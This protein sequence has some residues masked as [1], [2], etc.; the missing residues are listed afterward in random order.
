MN[1]SSLLLLPAAALYGG[2][3][4]ARNVY[5]DRIP[6]AAHTAALPVISVGNITAGGTGKT[7]LVIEIVRR[8]AAFGR[9]PAIL[10]RGYGGRPGQPADEVLELRAALSD[11]PVVVNPDRVAGAGEAERQ[12][13]DCVVLDDGFQHRRLRR[14]LDIV[15]VDALAPW[16]GGHLL[17]AGRLREPLAGLRRA[18]LFVITRVNL[19]PPGAAERA[20]A[21][22]GRWAGGRPVLA[23]SVRPEAVVGRGSQRE[24]PGVLAGRRVL[25]VAGLGNPR[26][27]ERTVAALAGEVRL[28]SFADHQRYAAGHVSRICAEV[29]RWG[30]EM[31]VTTRKD[32]GKLA[33]LW[34]DDG[35][36]LVRLDV[37]L[38]IEDRA[39]ELDAHLRRALETH[40]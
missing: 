17:P 3:V 4:R 38:T 27:F 1:L 29:E 9:R 7:P 13:A 18:G 22:L 10:T 31:V 28:L 12:G 37:R 24:V 16:G 25:A 11:T 26:G 8:L 6:T 32:W 33:A 23:A 35:P 20:A 2:V 40:P 14:D 34:P 21:E 5:Y 19:A 39:G 36:E 15:L 30:A